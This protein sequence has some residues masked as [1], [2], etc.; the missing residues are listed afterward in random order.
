MTLKVTVPP[1]LKKLLDPN[2]KEGLVAQTR[3]EFSKRGTIKVKQVIVQDMIRGIS[4]VAGAGKWKRYS[5]SYK[6]VIR[7]RATYF[8]QGR[9]TVR[10]GKSKSTQ[11][12]VNS[13]H[14]DFQ[15]KAKPTKQVSPV[16]LRYSGGLHRSLK[17]FTTGGVLR[18]FRM[19]TQ[20]KNFLADIHNRRGAGKSKVIRRLLPTNQ[21]ERFNR[22]IEQTIITELKKAADFVAKQFSRQ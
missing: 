13:R 5:P 19:I 16:N 20:F 3:K 6:D 2:N 4:P 8:K 17:V 15:A 21:G 14:R 11:R 1:K 7:G 12:F 18:N 10:V 22:R 9:R